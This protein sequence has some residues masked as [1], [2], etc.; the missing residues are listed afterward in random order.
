MAQQKEYLTFISGKRKNLPTAN[1]RSCSDVV[2]VRYSFGEFLVL[3]WLSYRTLK[4]IRSAF[5]DEPSD[6]PEREEDLKVIQRCM[7]FTAISALVQKAG[8]VA[9][10]TSF[11]TYNF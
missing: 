7:Q 11:Y 10:R 3:L 5:L 2:L 4:W 9:P 6:K 1:C 8:L